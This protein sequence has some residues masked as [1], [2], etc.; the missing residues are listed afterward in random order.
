MLPILLKENE[1][2]NIYNA[3]ETALFWQ[4]LPNKT[5]AEK[6]DKCRGEK[7]SKLRVS[8]LVASNMDG[9]DKRKLLVIGRFEKPRCFKG[10]GRLPVDY[11][12]NSKAWMTRSL[13]EEWV[14]KFDSQMAREKRKVVLIIDNCP[15]HLMPENLE[16]TR[17]VFL[18]PNS[19]SKTQPM[20]AGVIHSMKSHYRRLLLL[21]K[22]QA[23]EANVEY[24]PSLYTA[25]LLLTEAW[26]SVSSTTI[27]NCFRHCGF[28]LSQN[29]QDSTQGTSDTIPEKES[30]NIFDR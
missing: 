19:T 8:V 10:I 2:Q 25:I 23:M 14:R 5:L 3:D 12:A 18:P 29:S 24:N 11:K 17:V 21:R 22:L 15:A 28:D 26:E 9:S 20:D 27:A 1:P 13:F 30:R 7:K 6:G 16:C 4:L